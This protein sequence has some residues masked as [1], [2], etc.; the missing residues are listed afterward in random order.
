MRR[1]ETL[2]TGE[3]YHI[4][5]KTIAG[6]KVFNFDEDYLRMKQMI[7]Y[8][9]IAETPMPFSNFLNLSVVKSNGIDLSLEEW[10]RSR[11][12]LVQI[13]AYCI[14]P[15]HFHLVLK[16]LKADGITKFI[17]NLQNSYSRFFN[18]KRKRKGP[19][20]VGRFK[21]VRVETDE[22]LLH[23]T[24]YVHLNPVTASLVTQPEDWAASSFQEYLGA[25]NGRRICDYEGVLEINGKDYAAFVK[26]Q[27]DYQKQLARIKK[28]LLD[29]NL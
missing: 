7:V 13:L 22:Q 26:D 24:R 8:Y 2:T 9:A 18:T 11:S 4:F 25:A 21:N 23:L 15:T 3:T 16:Q 29:E 1:K 20:W 27:A 6:F 19:L 10:S 12:K 28:H 5:N 17:G 14:M